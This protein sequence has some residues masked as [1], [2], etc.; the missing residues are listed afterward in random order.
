MR[1][2]SE[3][4]VPRPGRRPRARHVVCPTDELPRGGT[5]LVAIGRRRI[6]VV[7]TDEDEYLAL[8]SHCP[9]QG[10]PLD[11]GT[12]ERMWVSDEVG[13]YSTSRKRFV[14]VCP[15]HNFEIEARRGCSPIEPARLRVAT[16]TVQVEDDHV[17]VYA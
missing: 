1:E 6:L 15:W 14:V 17:V 7:R 13:T 11:K 2:T 5:R 8:A 9:H 10:G 4:P 12:L 16:Y 3:Q